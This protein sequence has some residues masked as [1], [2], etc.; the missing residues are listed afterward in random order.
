MADFIPYQTRV[1]RDV[2]PD[3]VVRLSPDRWQSLVDYIRV[4]YGD[5]RPGVEITVY[6]PTD[7][8]GIMF[9]PAL[10]RAA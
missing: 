5:H 9:L 7:V 6:E 4:N 3:K 1:E 2:T 8:A 10:Y